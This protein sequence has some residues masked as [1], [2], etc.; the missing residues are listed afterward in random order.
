MQARLSILS[1]G[2]LIALGG[3]Q[4]LVRPEPVR[5]NQM[6]NAILALP[7]VFRQLKAAGATAVV[8]TGNATQG[9]MSP[10]EWALLVEK[11][12]PELEEARQACLNTL[13]VASARGLKVVSTKDLGA[14]FQD[15]DQDQE[16]PAPGYD[17]FET[18]ES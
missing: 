18:E 9:A 5:A 7:K 2:I 14:L 10:A 11:S 3:R 12:D 16:D 15:T 17:P 8:L 13:P 6:A 4:A 1:E